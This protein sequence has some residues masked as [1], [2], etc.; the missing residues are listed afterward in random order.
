MLGGL[1][2]NG[3]C[4]MLKIKLN[5]LSRS[6]QELVDHV[7]FRVPQSIHRP[8][9]R[10]IYRLLLDRLSTDMSI[11]CRPMSRSMYRPIHHTRYYRPI[12]P[13]IHRSRPPIRHMIQTSFP[14]TIQQPLR[15]QHIYFPFMYSMLLILWHSLNLHILL[16][17]YA[18]IVICY[19]AYLPP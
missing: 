6:V 13:P 5:G 19:C 16:N 17:K 9:H 1:H 12:Y 10:S 8:M 18:S 14:N 7:S 11:H 15:N 4:K 2:K 3:V